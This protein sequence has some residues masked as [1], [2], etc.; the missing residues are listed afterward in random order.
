MPPCLRDMGCLCAGH[1]RG[2]KAS[3]PCDTTEQVEA[4]IAEGK[5]MDDWEEFDSFTKGCPSDRLVRQ[6]HETD[7]AVH[8][9]RIER[10]III[11]ELAKRKVVKLDPLAEDQFHVRLGTRLDPP[12]PFSSSPPKPP[13][14]PRKKAEAK[15][16]PLEPGAGT[17]MS[18]EKFVGSV[19]AGAFVDD[20]GFAE[21]ATATHVSMRG[22]GPGSVFTI[23]RPKWATHVVWYNK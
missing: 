23:N 14:K 7:L 15:L 2:N 5:T 17:H 11:L 9:L 18:W 22:V 21:L 12:K 20:D 16:R 3:E 6:L 10:A 19:Q 8:D 13:K 4:P 1:A